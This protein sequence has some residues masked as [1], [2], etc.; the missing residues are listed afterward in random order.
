MRLRTLLLHF[1]RSPGIFDLLLH[2]VGVLAGDP[3]LERLG[4]ALDQVLGLLESEAGE[5]ADHLDDLDLVGAEAGEDDVELRLLLRDGGRRSGSRNGDRGRRRRHAEPVLERL[6]DVV[7]LENGHPLHH[8]DEFVL[9]HGSH[10][11]RSS[12]G[13]CGMWFRVQPAAASAGFCLRMDSRTYTSL[14]G[15]PE[16][17][18]A[19]RVIGDASPPTSRESSTSREGT[20]ARVSTSF[21][22]RTRPSTNP[23]RSV[24]FRLPAANSFIAF[25]SATGSPWQNATAVGP[26][27]CAERS[28]NGVP[29][30][31]RR[32]RVFFTTLSS[33]SIAP[34]F[35]RRAVISE[36]FS[37]RNE[38]TTAPRCAAM[39]AFNASTVSVLLVF[40][41]A[42][43]SPFPFRKIWPL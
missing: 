10:F 36:T 15:G 33:A 3:F 18:C 1:R 24:T 41:T 42:S 39:A 34:S 27:K 29:S 35:F 4:N 32:I 12:L 30:A 6:H 9:V 22:E 20:L 14:R 13:F 43:V 17:A 28:P 19:R 16:S 31:A 26:V 25:A 8:R 5:L 11:V 21:A 40:F 37:P 38:A 2:P 7:K 23:A